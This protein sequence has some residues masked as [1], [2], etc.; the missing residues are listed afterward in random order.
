[1]NL[2]FRLAAKASAVPIPESVKTAGTMKSVLGW[3]TGKG[4]VGSQKAV[5]DFYQAWSATLGPTTNAML[6]VG[7]GMGS[8]FSKIFY[9]IGIVLAAVYAKM[10]GLL[11]FLAKGNYAGSSQ[12]KNL[13]SFLV[14][15]GFAILA[16][17]IIAWAIASMAGRPEFKAAMVSV[18]A[19]CSVII[20]LPWL[21]GEFNAITVKATTEMNTAVTG[22]KSGTF[23]NSLNNVVLSPFQDNTIDW[24][25]MADHN[26]N[27]N[28]KKIGGSK[29]WS[30]Y[31]LIRT[32]NINSVN[33]TVNIAKDNIGY[34]SEKNKT[35]T[36]VFK[37]QLDTGVT[38]THNTKVAKLDLPATQVSGITHMGQ[39]VYPRYHVNW[40]AV[41]M[42]L[43]L[44]DGFFLLAGYK[45][46]K[47]SI[48]IFFL[49]LLSP[50]VALFRVQSLK[51]VKELMSAIIGAS[52][53]IFVENAGVF[54]LIT[55][56]QVTSGTTNFIG[57][58]ASGWQRVIATLMIYG[59]AIAVLIAG[60]EY[61]QRW[62]GTSTGQ[63]GSMRD[64]AAGAMAGAGLARATKTT[65]KA[66]VG[67]IK[68]VAGMVSSAGHGIKDAGSKA[69]SGV[70]K[71]RSSA[72]QDEGGD[73]TGS[74]GN[75]AN[76]GDKL[77]A[78]KTADTPSDEAAEGTSDRV[79]N[80]T[81]TNG[82]SEGFKN[83]QSQPGNEAADHPEDGH[84]DLDGADTD[85][86]LNDHN[87]AGEY[88]NNL[89]P[90]QDMPADDM[91]SD[92]TTNAYDSPVSPG[93]EA[94]DNSD[95]GD[96]FDYQ[97][98]SA[99]LDA[100]EHTDQET[101]DN[102]GCANGSGISPEQPARTSSGP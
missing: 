58:M 55:V 47:Y 87:G 92:T 1:M 30:K 37:Y 13:H 44:L 80:D 61:I 27:T 71:M 56:I 15:L 73:S 72:L 34:V 42:E 49:M 88:D 19:A 32:N 45:V 23:Q 100:T 7:Y 31:N 53:G 86:G 74:G 57:G 14:V 8:F 54:F 77:N 28:P 50:L 39:L 76:G 16:V 40:I 22:K 93:L 82:Q 97:E 41:I 65:G 36:N 26:L 64:L 46:G 62:S 24:L 17:S 20:L 96:G 84:T 3:L 38:D 81:N 78:A 91:D 90:T 5:I 43:I 29:G 67:G 48:K 69:K 25:N 12:V 63:S 66:A 60:D 102:R 68:G 11:G 4:S 95:S 83:G 35:N 99:S 9:N 2:I 18:M 98:G 10:F 21:V 75:A 94:S 70:E 89:D 79:D 33:F 101:S 85:N 59:A 52:T 6:T 51:N